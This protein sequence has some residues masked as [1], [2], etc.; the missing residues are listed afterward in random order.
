MELTRNP[1]DLQQFENSK[2]RILNAVMDHT[3]NRFARF[4][5][6]DL[7]TS[8]Q[9]LVD[10]AEWP[11]TAEELAGFG[12]DSLQTVATHF[13]QP[14]RQVG[15]DLPAARQEWTALKAYVHRRRGV[16][17]RNVAQLWNHLFNDTRD[18]FPNMLPLA[19]IILTYPLNT[20]CCERGFSIMKKIKHDWRA[21]LLP[22]TL[23]MLMRVVIDGPPVAQFNPRRSMDHWWFQGPRARRPNYIMGHN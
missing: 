18:R 9:L 19:E 2:V 11:E 12:V 23:A 4:E 16:Y 3:Q 14:L 7:L 20:A 6:D 17:R 15:F 22:Q 13:Q 5:D 1:L 21:S 10:P 8:S